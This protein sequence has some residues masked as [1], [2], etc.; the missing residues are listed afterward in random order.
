MKNIFSLNLFSSS[1]EDLEKS[2]PNRLKMAKFFQY[3]LQRLGFE[4]Q[5]SKDNLFC[6]LS[7]LAPKDLE[8]KRDKIVEMLRKDHVFCTRIWHTP[9]ILN[10]EEFPNTFEAAKRVIN[11]PLQNHYTEKDIKKIIEAVKRVIKDV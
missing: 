9:I 11:F 3:E 10:K 8:E 1:L 2:L 7:A 5:E 6:Y 4:A